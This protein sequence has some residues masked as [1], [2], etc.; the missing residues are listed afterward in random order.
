MKEKRLNKGDKVA[1]RS[2][3]GT[4]TGKV[5]GKTTKATKIKTHRVAA[6]KS[7]PQ[8]IVKSDKTGA[9]AAHKASALKKKG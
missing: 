2:S 1:W 3:Q 4:V 8:Y 5:V 6:S 7:N 9:K